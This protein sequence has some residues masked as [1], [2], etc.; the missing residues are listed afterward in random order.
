M[1]ADAALSRLVEPL[2]FLHGAAAADAIASGLALPFMGGPAAFTLARLHG[3][4]APAHPVRVP[5]VGGGF[6]DALAVVIAPPPAAVLPA[7]PLVMGILNATPDSFSDGG[8]RRDPGAGIAA[9]RGF[10]ADGAAIVDIGGESTR[11]GAV[12]PPVGEEIRRVLPLVEALRD[13]GA[14]LSIDTRRSKVMRAALDSGASMVNDVSGLA[15]DPDSIP[16]LAERDCT[17]SIM[18]MRGTP[19]TM[20]S[21]TDYDDVALDT[22]RELASRVAAAV[23]GGIRRERILVDPGIGFAKTAE[24]SAA[25]LRR[26][27]ILANLG[28]RIVLGVS[29][30]SFIRRFAAVEDARERGPGTLAASA[31]ARAFPDPIH[32]VHDVASFAQFL[33]IENA[34][35]RPPVS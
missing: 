8:A 4:D 25:L 21:L 15:Y 26:L 9:A 10:V 7:G 22:C 23:R 16:L 29:R 28:A 19:E 27:P 14:V 30:K 11:P 2:A 34:L 13:A 20:T 17:V 6:R 12:P 3:P 24:G 1:N 31:A 18:H 35:F 32:R 33:R 5:E